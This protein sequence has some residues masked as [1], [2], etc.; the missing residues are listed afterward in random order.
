VVVDLWLFREGSLL[1]L[2]RQ[3]FPLVCGGLSQRK[4]NLVRLDL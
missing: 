1:V 3:V 2:V 4:D